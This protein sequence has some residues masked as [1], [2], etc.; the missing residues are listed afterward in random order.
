MPDSNAEVCL[1]DKSRHQQMTMSNEKGKKRAESFIDALIALGVLASGFSAFRLLMEPTGYSWLLLVFVTYLI[2][3][4]VTVRTPGSKAEVTLYDTFLFVGLFVHGTEAGSLLGAV[5][6]YGAS[7]AVAKTWRTLLVNMATITLSLF[8]SGKATEWLLQEPLLLIT[9]QH[10]VGQFVFALGFLT[11]VYFAINTGTVALVLAARTGRNIL[12]VWTESCLWSSFT[13]FV[14]ALVAALSIKTVAVAD[15]HSLLILV[16]ILLITWFSYRKFFERIEQSYAETKNLA[17]LNQD[18]IEALAL[19]IDAKDRI[20]QGHVRRVQ[21]VAM[22]IADEM[23]VKDQDLLKALHIASLLHD[24]GK[25]AIPDQILNKPGPL[26]EAEF[27]KVKIHPEISARILSDIPFPYPVVPI[28]RAHH[29]RWDGQG[30]PQK[31]RGEEIPLGARI[32]AVADVFDGLHV[33]RGDSQTLT[34][35]EIVA[36]IRQRSGSHLDPVV[37]E[38]C[39]RTSSRIEDKLQQALIPQLRLEKSGRETATDFRNSGKQAVVDVYQNIADAQR[40]VMDLYEL[41]QTLAGTLESETLL[42]TLTV[43]LA[44]ITNYDSCAIFLADAPGENVRVA[45]AIGSH[46][47]ELK[48]QQIAWGYGLSGWVAANN[49][50]MINAQAHLDFSFLG[51]GKDALLHALSVPLVFQDELLGV[52]T[53]YTRDHCYTPDEVRLTQA[54]TRHAATALKNI[55]TLEKTRLHASTDSLTGLPN[56]R[57]LISLLEKRLTGKD[58]E[59][60]LTLLMLDLDGFKAVNDSFGH[61]A[62]DEMLRQ[63]SYLLR[64]HLRSDDVLIRQG[65]DE[66][67]AVLESSS[68]LQIDQMVQRLQSAVDSFSLKLEDAQEAKVGVSIG[69]A[70]FPTDGKTISELIDAAD[71]R[72]YSNKKERKTRQLPRLAQVRTGT[73]SL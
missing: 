62:G 65:G 64:Q 46:S 48:D 27:E 26:T 10:S 33:R 41:S 73:G 45:Y 31:L 1:N 13:H 66:F 60:E 22:E 49:A 38:A 43:H 40:E 3:R 70:L 18:T 34:H 55:L 17:K 51:Q 42:E 50:P 44:K 68:S 36:E 35:E 15:Y 23:G 28:V 39:C 61:Q 58:A 59:K 20:S 53:L 29:E 6:G 4:H 47:D 69:R 5:A 57:H 52:L 16:P 67:V 37:V 7:V 30:Y 2:S 71:Q 63:I 25:L 11:L 14:G 9:R 19:A 32:L 72:M 21:V 56:G 24:I 12:E 54:F 8:T